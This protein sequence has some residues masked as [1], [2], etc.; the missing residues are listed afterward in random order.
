LSHE[1]LFEGMKGRVDE[2]VLQAM[3]KVK[4][5]LFVPEKC[6]SLA[7][8][9]MPLPIGHGQTISAPHMVAIMV[10]LLDLREGMKVL[11]IGTGS[12]YHAAVMA[13]LVGSTGYIYSVEVIPELVKMAGENLNVAGIEN[14][15]VIQGDGSLGLPEYAPYDRINVAASAPEVPKPLMDQL[16]KGGKMAVPV[17]SYYQELVLVTK[18][19]GSTSQRLMAVAFVPLVGRF[20]HEG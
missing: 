13:Q 7:Y 14:V 18:E 20:G 19:D 11:D 17:G 12:G 3:M 15:T 8:A 1:S 5:E 16:A 6:K 4:R 10:Q 9:D 2:R